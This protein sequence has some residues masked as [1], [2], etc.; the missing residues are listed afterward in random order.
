MLDLNKVMVVGRLTRDPEVRHI[1]T[2]SAVAKFDIAVNRRYRDPKTG[3]NKEEVCYLTVEAWERQ[4]EFVEQYFTK[5]KAIYV[6]GR[7][8][9]DNWEK[10]GQKFSRLLIRADRLQFAE[11][12][13]EQEAR[14]AGSAGAAPRAAANADAD[15][16][17]A[18]EAPPSDMPP[19]PGPDAG[20]DSG[21]TDDDLPF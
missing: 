16:S 6:E 21:S 7:L 5:G 4:A 12:R 10:D 19:M 17:A 2:G 18:A 14:A 3:E 20:G 15:A 13:A 9:Q 11:S 8:R 1:Q